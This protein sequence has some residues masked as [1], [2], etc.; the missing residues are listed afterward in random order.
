MD[1][2]GKQSINI[3]TGRTMIVRQMID[4]LCRHAGYRPHVTFDASRPQMIRSR[5]LDVNA[6]KRLLGWEATTTMED[7]LT[8][9][10][11]WYETHR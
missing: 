5:L 9:T 1:L 7:G 2:E 8:M 4:V 3:G 6:A 11:D 10:L